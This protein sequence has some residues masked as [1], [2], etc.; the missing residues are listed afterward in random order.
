MR[1]ATRTCRRSEPNAASP[2]QR[3]EYRCTPWLFT[4]EA[5]LCARLTSVFVAGRH[6]IRHCE[7]VMNRNELCLLLSVI[8]WLAACGDDSTPS[9][10]ASVGTD[11]GPSDA[12]ADVAPT[13]LSEC[14]SHVSFPEETD[15]GLDPLFQRMDF[16]SEELGIHMRVAIS[17]DPLDRIIGLAFNFKTR[18]LAIEDTDG[19]SCIRD[20]SQLTYNVTQH[21]DTDSFTAMVSPDERYVVSMVYDLDTATVTDS[22]TIEHPESG[23][24]MD[25]PYPLLEAGCSVHRED[26]VR[27]C[28][29]QT[30]A[31][32]E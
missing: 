22:L 27:D 11:S 1:Y 4:N 15:F 9:F 25:G 14:V 30:R 10:D 19:L 23:A 16:V 5:T 8:V 31:P 7:K 21:N 18:A 6:P 32:Y 28:T 2:A 29:Y 20:E 26:G 13:T 17:P 24:P 3:R 12:R